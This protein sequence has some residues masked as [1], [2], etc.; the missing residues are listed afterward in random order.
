VSVRSCVAVCG[1][2]AVVSMALTVKVELPLARGVP[3]MVPAALSERPA[4]RVPDARDHV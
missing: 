2:G 3:E 4:G 1:V